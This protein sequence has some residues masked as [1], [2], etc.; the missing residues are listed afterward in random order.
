MSAFDVPSGAR[1]GA[2]GAAAPAGHPIAEVLREL[3]AHLGGVIGGGGGGGPPVVELYGAAGALGAAVAA[4]LARGGRDDHARPR[5][6]SS[7]SR[8]R[9]RPLV[10]L[11]ADEDTAEARVGD[12]AFFLPPEQA[13]EDPLEPPAVLLYPAPDGSPYAEVQP[14]RRTL[15]GRMAALYRLSH[16]LGPAV[17]VASAAAFFRRVFPRAAF[18]RRSLVL[19]APAP[20][21]RDAT[22][23]ALLDAGYGRASVVED[24]G[25]FAVR[26]AVIDLYPPIYRHPVRLE[27]FGDEVESI[28]LYDAAT[29]RTLRPIREVHIHPVRETIRTEGADPRARLLEAADAAV[30]PS[31]KTRLVIEHVEAGESFFGIEA[32]APAF[33]AA[34][35]PLGA[36]LPEDALFVVEDPAAVLAEA[37]RAAA[38]LRETAASRRAEHRLALDAGGFALGEDE[39]EAVLRGRP[40]IELRTVEVIGRGGS[41]DGDEDEAEDGDGKEIARARVRIESQSLATLRAE[42]QQARA[43]EVRADDE[44]GR[45]HDIDIGKPL[46][47]RLRAWLHQGMRVRIAVPNRTHAQRLGAVLASWELVPEVA[48]GAG[49]DLLD[50]AAGKAGKGGPP[51]GLAIGPLT[52]GFALPADRLVL[53]AEEEIFGRRAV[54]E[55]R[56]KISAPAIGDLG[57]IEEGDPVVHEEH[58]IGR[59]R[60]LKQLAVRGVAQDFLQLEYDGGSVYVPVYRI[61]LVHRY[62]GAQ[63]ENAA[64]RLD[65]LGGKTWQ[66][67]RRR[68]SA[69]ARKI[70]EE[71]LQLYA[72][73]AALSGH[74]FPAPDALFR[75]FEETF[76]FDE[77]PDQQTAIDAVLGDMQAGRPMDRLVCGD[78]GYGKTEV[79]LRAT[80]LAV[81]G[82]KQVAVLAPTTVLAEQ[83]FV[84]FAERMNEFPVKVAVLSRFRTRAEQ[85]K[86]IADLAA[87]KIDVLVGTHRILSRDVRFRDLGLVVV[88][89]EQRFGVTHKER[90]KELRTQVDV[91]TLTATPIPRTLQMAMGG[92]REISIIAT[93]PAD[94][95]AIRTFVCCWDPQLLGDAVKKELGRGGQVFF[96][97]N[98]IEDLAKWTEK[99]RE[100]APPGARVAMAHGQMAEGELEKV[101]VDFVDGRHDVLVSTTIIESGLDIP[102]ANTMIVNRADRFGL[103]QLYQMRGRIGRAKE[104]AFCYLVVPEEKQMT[105]EAKQRLAVLQR[106]TELGAGF[107][108][109]THDLEIRGAGELLGEK[110]SGAVAAVGFETYAQILEEAVAELKGE[111]IRAERDPEISVDLPAFLPGDYVPDTGQR[112]DFYRRLARAEDED[113]V[114]ATLIELQDRY[115]P[116]PDE[117]GLL[118]E[119]MAQ[120][121]VVRAIGALGYELAPGRLVLAL[122]ADSPLDPAKVLKLASRKQSRWKLS[123]DM[124]LS[125]AFDDAERADRLAAARRLLEEVRACLPSARK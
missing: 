50:L 96:V 65:K 60:G 94:R 118:G 48:T 32:L 75:E 115:G 56:Q 17:L 53:L 43:A 77:T 107:Q 78:V 116:L 67:K 80:L 9:P 14:D 59:Y 21:D 82:G 79:A 22:V 58:G 54:R 69:E 83:H 100:L 5:S 105:D 20:I 68:V 18:D 89:E 125:Y 37:R 38:K 73:R 57:E 39:A 70:A 97:H 122:G 51:L 52:H 62:S 86:T 11:V 72:Q 119:V 49:G 91:L 25:T 35:E 13:G 4:H 44:A 23:R 98:R 12:V 76:P 108:V 123:P 102:R 113:G 16:G 19:T 84:T 31:S 1:A 55:S 41:G 33:H 36:Y 3:E 92:L 30:Y 112:L 71:L 85:Q 74:T 114:R 63:G 87:G 66:E 106:F 99:V 45:E 124:R 27:L 46:R 2:A 120:K 88:D 61:G 121:T 28:R 10:Y 93:P 47:D 34:M 101:M 29:Q 95:L 81:L 103:A 64:V 8:S 110:Q 6:S 109:A 90:L 42:L 104:R 111:P 24:A 117:A 26:G 7:R 40:R 15:L